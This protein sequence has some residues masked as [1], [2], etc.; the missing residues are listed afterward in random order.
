M[1][2]T[3]WGLVKG[4]LYILAGLVLSGASVGWFYMVFTTAEDEVSSGDE[5]WIAIF[6]VSILMVFAFIGGLQCICYGIAYIGGEDLNE[7]GIERSTDE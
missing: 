1:K 3:K 2:C 4:I 7:R 5:L 6:F